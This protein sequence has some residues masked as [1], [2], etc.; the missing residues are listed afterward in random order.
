MKDK[1]PEQS[2]I[3]DHEREAAKFSGWIKE[4]KFSFPDLQF[5]SRV[6]F[7]PR[8][9]LALVAVDVMGN[10]EAK[11]KTFAAMLEGR[12]QQKGGELRGEADV[13]KNVGNAEYAKELGPKQSKQLLQFFCP[14]EFYFGENTV[15]AAKSQKQ[16][17]P[18]AM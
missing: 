2:H 15:R 1:H 11:I 18:F 6:A 8:G 13:M 10:S 4:L 14:L 16:A 12:A 7:S 17:L 3:P 9:K 5:D